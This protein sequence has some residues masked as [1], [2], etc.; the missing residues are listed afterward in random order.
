MQTIIQN[1]ILTATILH[2][3]AE[4]AA[5]EKDGKNYIWD[6]DRRFW[7]K[8]SPVLFPVIGGLKDD[9]FEYKGKKYPLPRHGFAREKVFE[10]VSKSDDSAVFALKSDSDSLKVYPFDFELLISYTLRGSELEV[11]YT[12]RNLSADPMYYSIGAHPA[13]RIE[14]AFE[15]YALKFDTSNTLTTFKLAENGLFSGETVDVSVSE[16]LL[17]LNYGLFEKDALV[18]KNHS[19]DSLTLLYYNQP[20][21]KVSFKDFPYLGIWT[22]KDAPFLCIEPWRGIADNADASGKIEEKEG[23]QVLDSLQ[24]QHFQWSVE[25]F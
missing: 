6:I 25:V 8:T 23:I 14:H 7:D 21:L 11:K 24:V 18:L 22:K 19:T 15:D 1:E 20:L 9:V 2:K 5:L 4:L 12:V 16:T 13:F 3:G 10:L 17:P